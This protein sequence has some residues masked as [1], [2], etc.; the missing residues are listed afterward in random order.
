MHLELTKE[1]IKIVPGTVQDEVF[2]LAKLRLI[3]TGKHG[4]CAIFNYVPQA[5][6]FYLE[7][8]IIK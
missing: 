6:T 3:P 8:E 4:I 7:S 5:D 2:I 1:T